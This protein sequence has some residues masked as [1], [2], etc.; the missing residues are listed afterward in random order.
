MWHTKKIRKQKKQFRSERERT[1]ADIAHSLQTPLAIL[2]SELFF[3]KQEAPQQGRAVLCDRLIDTVSHRVNAFLH[4]S[5]LEHT[6]R[7][8]APSRVLLSKLLE[9]VVGDMRPL[10]ESHGISIVLNLTPNVYIFG[11]QDK[12]YELFMNIMSNSIKYMGFGTTRTITLSLSKT[13][14]HARVSFADTGI[15]IPKED[16]PNLYTSLFRGKNGKQQTGIPG[17]GLGLAIVKRI[18]DAHTGTIQTK[19]AV[20]KGTETVLRFPLSS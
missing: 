20:N 18:V 16:I 5:T 8:E 12:L 11:V 7:E 6:L 15:G 3:L 4:I 2:K 1:L 14:R 17:S 9:V 19:S 13:A 10:A